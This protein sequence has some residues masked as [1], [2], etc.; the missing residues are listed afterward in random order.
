MKKG[1]STLPVETE[2]IY[3][4]VDMDPDKNQVEKYWLHPPTE[5]KSAPTSWRDFMIDMKRHEIIALLITHIRIHM[6][7]EI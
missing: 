2:V 6:D 5:V 7:T 3:E 1:T 4:D